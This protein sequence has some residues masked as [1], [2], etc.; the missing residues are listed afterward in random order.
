MNVPYKQMIA[1]AALLTSA[2][3]AVQAQEL[4]E[5]TITGEVLIGTDYRFRGISQ[6]D[7]SFTVQGGIE[8]EHESGFYA[9]LWGSN[10]S[11]SGGA[12]EL[13][14]YVGFSGSFNSEIDFDIGVLY[15]GYPKDGASPSLDF[16]EIYASISWAGIDF[17][18]DYSPDY[19][20]GTGRYFY[21]HGAYEVELPGE[22]SL[23]FHL[24]SNIFKNRANMDD[25]LEIAGTGVS[26]GS[27]YLD[28]SITLSKEAYGLDWSLS[29]VDTDLS[30]RECFGG[31]KACS[32]TAV[33]AVSKSF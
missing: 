16:W 6:T 13:D 10:V 25:F 9:G 17:G 27:S 32:A 31:D 21:V 7:R 15:Y 14:P 29:Y 3:T 33:F 2:M 26:A 22:F 5:G 12:L 28:W 11:F 4:T 23:G 1:G 18:V 19:F 24:G 8:Y 30:R 20:A